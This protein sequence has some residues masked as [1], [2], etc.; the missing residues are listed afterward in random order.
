MS[1][2]AIMV[3]AVTTLKFIKEYQAIEKSRLTPTGWYW[4]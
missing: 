4:S 1:A 2:N 3:T